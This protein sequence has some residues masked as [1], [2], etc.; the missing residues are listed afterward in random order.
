MHTIGLYLIGLML[1]AIGI[2]VIICSIGV[3]TSF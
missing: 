2:V 3:T 1:I